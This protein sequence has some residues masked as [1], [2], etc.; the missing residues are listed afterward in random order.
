MVFPVV[1]DSIGALA[2]PSWA[3]HGRPIKAIGDPLDTHGIP[4]VSHG[5]LVG[6]LGAHRKPVRLPWVRTT[7]PWKTHGNTLVDPWE[8]V[9]YCSMEP[10]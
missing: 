4:Q 1:E 6:T 9:T 5:S 3:F 10:L 8:S 2:S 7:S